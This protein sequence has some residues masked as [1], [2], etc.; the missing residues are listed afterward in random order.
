MASDELRTKLRHVFDKFDAD[1]SGCVSA[2]EMT[3][4]FAQLKINMTVAQISTMMKEADPD[5]SG[6]IDF[7]EFCA[8]A[9]K[10]ME[11]GGQLASVVDSAS[12][13]FGF[14]S[15]NSANPA[16]MTPSP[17]SLLLPVAED[18]PQAEVATVAEG[19]SDL[20]QWERMA[21]YQPWGGYFKMVWERQKRRRLM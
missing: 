1:S 17:F 10:Q 9:S 18:A 21:M 2:D 19:A 14:F 12:S 20:I 5:G 4:I 16:Q 11:A 8:V 13:F 3:S 7:D 6:S 15:A